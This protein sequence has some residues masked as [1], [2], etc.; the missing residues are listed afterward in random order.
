MAK[1]CKQYG[2]WIEAVMEAGGDFF[3]EIDFSST[4]AHNL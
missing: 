2:H 3:I 1:V 4:S